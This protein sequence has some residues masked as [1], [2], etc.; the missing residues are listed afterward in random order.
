MKFHSD[1]TSPCFSIQ[2][3]DIPMHLYQNVDIRRQQ[4]KYLYD[5]ALESSHTE[6]PSR[7]YSTNHL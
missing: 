5:L 3:L 1:S 7:P 2:Q 6:V 4:N